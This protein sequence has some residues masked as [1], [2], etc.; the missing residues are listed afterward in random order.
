MRFR[1]TDTV[2]CSGQVVL[3]SGTLSHPLGLRS[4]HEEEGGVSTRHEAW[5]AVDHI[6]Y[7]ASAR[8][9]LLGKLNLPSSRQMAVVGGI[10]NQE[11]PSDHLPLVADFLLTSSPS[12]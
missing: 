9:R 2:T 12:S 3:G 6:F 8:L 11:C 4:V 5:L 10:P 1:D 7:S